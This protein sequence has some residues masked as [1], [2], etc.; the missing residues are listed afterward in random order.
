[1]LPVYS[2]LSWCRMECRKRNTLPMFITN[3]ILIYLYSPFH[4][5]SRGGKQTERNKYYSA[6]LPENT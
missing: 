3:L 2:V 1:M 6:G 5:F 4:P